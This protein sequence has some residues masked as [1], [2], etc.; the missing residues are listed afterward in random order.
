ML[1]LFNLHIA[2]NALS[3]IL[4]FMARPKLTGKP[5]KTA[6]LSVRLTEDIKLALDALG[7][8]TGIMPG[9]VVARLAEHYVLLARAARE[10]GAIPPRAA[11][12]VADFISKHGNDAA[13]AAAVVNSETK[14]VTYGE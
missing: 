12:C 13:G 8:D 9:K 4:I 1:S 14:K 5:K 7:D 11:D 6:T 2:H 3:C 10:R